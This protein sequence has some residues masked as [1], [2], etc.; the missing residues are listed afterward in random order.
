MKILDLHGIKHH[1]VS[2]KVEDFILKNQYRL[3]L[4]IITG[5]S[6]RMQV[7]CFEVIE[8]HDFG[9]YVPSDNLGQIIVLTN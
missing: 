9:Y 8:R 7:L 3:P 2:I 5:N 1:E 6:K 4:K